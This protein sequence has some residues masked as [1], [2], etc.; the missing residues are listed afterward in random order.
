MVKHYI[1]KDGKLIRTNPF[2][3]RCGAGVFMAARG[4]WWSCGKCGDRY[5]QK[6]FNFKAEIKSN[7]GISGE[8]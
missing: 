2:C 1:I 5:H 4:G 7:K 3:P 8:G 6:I